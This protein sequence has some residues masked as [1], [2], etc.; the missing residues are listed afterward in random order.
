[1]IESLTEEEGTLFELIKKLNRSIG[2]HEF[3]MIMSIT[4]D[5][6]CET[7]YRFQPKDWEVIDERY[8]TGMGALP[9]SQELHENIDSLVR[10]GYVDRN[11]EKPIII[12]ESKQLQLF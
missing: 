5:G 9:Y 10:K 7:G 2:E 8:E 4:Q 6:G 3:H 11:S 1:M 12:S